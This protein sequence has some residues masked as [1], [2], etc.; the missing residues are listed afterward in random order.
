MRRNIN[1][2]TY[3]R[4][5]AAVLATVGCIIWLSL[6][7]SAI[8]SPD[9]LVSRGVANDTRVNQLQMLS[10]LPISFEPNRGQ[11]D[12]EVK[13]RSQ[14]ILQGGYQVE[15]HEDGPRLINEVK[16]KVESIA[17]NFPGSAR[18]VRIEA[19]DR[20]PGNSNYFIG[21]DKSAW[22]TGLP[23]YGKVTYRRIYPG[24]D[25]VLYGRS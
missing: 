14:A 6:V 10:Q 3:S 8:E 15:L 11:W 24:I 22:I 16:G 13:Y 17:L 12:Q 19:I 23:G 4:L 21:N 2:S 25:L 7:N 9:S 5:T 1:R 18:A 20:L